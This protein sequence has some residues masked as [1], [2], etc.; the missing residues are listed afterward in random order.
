MVTG[1]WS[2]SAQELE[3][4]IPHLDKDVQLG[5][6]V[7]VPHNEILN[8]TASSSLPIGA[9]A[10]SPIAL[11]FVRTFP[12]KVN[13]PLDSKYFL[14]NGLHLGMAV[15]DVEMTQ[16]CIATHQCRE[17]NPLMPSSQAGELGVSFALVGYGSYISYRLKRH[18]THTWWIAPVAGA[19]AH[20]VGAATGLEH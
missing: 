7:A 12:V 18:G 14:L 20:A 15:F 11:T 8:G 16:H 5:A 10:P 9:L 13:H 4:P 19:S 6:T 3:A 1:A 2:C 17:G